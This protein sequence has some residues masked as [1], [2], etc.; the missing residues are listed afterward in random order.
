MIFRTVAQI[1][2]LIAERSDAPP[3]LRFWLDHVAD[4]ECWL[5]APRP[6]W[7]IYLARIEGVDPDLLGRLTDI[8][9]EALTLTEARSRGVRSSLP[10][11]NAAIQIKQMILNNNVPSFPPRTDHY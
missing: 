10:L 11:F 7:L 1:R 3:Q 4:T 6:D 8:A 2:D 5:E 9:V